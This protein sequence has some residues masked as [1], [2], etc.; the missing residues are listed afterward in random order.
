MKAP[1]FWYKS[2]GLISTLLWPASLFY[3]MG[4]V[5]RRTVASPYH[6]KIPVICIGNII[7]GGAGKTPVT[8]TLAKMMQEKGHKPVFVTRGYGGRE[9]GPLQV[10]LSRHTARDVGDEALLLARV[11]P[12]WIGRDRAAA[13]RAAEPHG[14]HI[15]IDDGLQNPSIL[16]DLAF[17]VI[18]GSIAFGNGRLI[19]AGPLRETFNE[20][21]RR[22]TA[23]ILI[24]DDAGQR[25]TPRL[26]CPV[27]RAHWH[28]DFP[29]DFPHEQNF[30]AFA[31]IG[32]PEKFYATCAEAGV[33]LV[34]TKDFP[35]HHMF[36]TGELAGLQ[37]QAETLGARLL[38][39]EKDWV[40]LPPGFQ[41]K[42]TVFRARLAF[43]ESEML[44]KMI[45]KS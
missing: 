36:S 20:A 37:K 34:G 29:D 18:D 26:R 33:T 27:I 41:D 23:I 22:V 30:Y 10:D 17:L 14:T 19:P 24:G 38:T 3:R 21:M 25:I 43:D 7:A 28:P 40:R 45:D 35:D 13:I 12:L 8:L 6:A 32:R 2:P 39:T 4:G 44:I 42:V 15:I 11:A 1:A 5:I 9:H 16:P 31:G